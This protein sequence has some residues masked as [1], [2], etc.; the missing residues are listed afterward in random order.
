MS[1]R[2]TPETDA[3]WAAAIGKDAKVADIKMVWLERQRDEFRALWERDSKSLGVAIGQRNTARAVADDNRAR[4]VTAESERNELAE[5]LRE[6]RKYIYYRGLGTDDVTV[7]GDNPP[8]IEAILDP[9]DALLA[10]IEGKS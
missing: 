6:A 4:Y 5:A 3:E 2:E 8:F 1:E 9:I 7:Y 10:R